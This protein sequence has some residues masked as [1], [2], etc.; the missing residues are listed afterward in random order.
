MKRCVCFVIIIFLCACGSQ[1]SPYP[2][3]KDSQIKPQKQPVVIHGKA[4]FAIHN[5]PIFLKS[6]AEALVEITYVNSAATDFSINTNNLAPNS[7]ATLV[8][9]TLRLGQVGI[10]SLSDNNLKVCGNDGHTKCNQAI[11]SVYTNGSVAG[12]INTAGGYGAPVFTGSLNPTQALGLGA[13]NAVVV[14]TY[15]IPA[16]QN[17]LS[18][19][20]FPSP[21]YA[22]TSDFSNAGAGSYSMNYV[23]QYALTINAQ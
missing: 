8:G 20:D 4:E 21:R 13:E 12:F 6:N 10:A 15:S 1:N 11:I 19:S 5:E 16:R 3:V 2:Q 23:V 7:P 9:E 14:Q 17:V 22:V 18:L